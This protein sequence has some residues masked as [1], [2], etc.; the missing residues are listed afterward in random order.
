MS[1]HPT[2]QEPAQ[3]ISPAVSSNADAGS[4]GEDTSFQQHIQSRLETPPIAGSSSPRK[5]STSVAKGEALLNDH[6]MHTSLLQTIRTKK[7]YII[8]MD[9]VI[10]HVCLLLFFFFLSSGFIFLHIALIFHL[11][12]L[13]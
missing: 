5:L 4:A 13:G 9:G 7:G 2:F 11:S 3:I 8:D 10:Y 6:E 1:Q 12:I